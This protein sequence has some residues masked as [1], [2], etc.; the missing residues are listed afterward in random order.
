MNKQQIVAHWRIL[1]DYPSNDGEYVVVF[2]KDSGDFGWVDVWEFSSR[3]S[4]EPI[5]GQDHGQ[6]PV[7]WIDLP[8]PR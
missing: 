8:M 2:Q 3:Y 6:Q 4:W 1:E 7:Y 5:Y